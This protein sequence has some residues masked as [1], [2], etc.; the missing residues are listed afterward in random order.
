MP[1]RGI[2]LL[3]ALTVLWGANW[4][5]MKLALREVAPWTFRTVCLVTGGIGLLGIA[6]AGG[7]PLRI[8]P[9]ERGPLFLAAVFNITAWHMF[10]AY[11]V[12]LIQASRAVIIAYTM[13]LWT[14]LLGRILFGEPLTRARGVALVLGLAGLAVLIGPEARIFWKAPLG[15]LLV[16]AAAISWAAGT[17]VVKQ[18]RWTMPT[19]V[20][21]GWQV[22]LGGLPVVI[23]Q[24]LFEPFP[25]PAD[26]SLQALL[27]T[28]Y[29][30]V[31]GI[32]VCHYAWFRVVELLPSAIAAIGTLGIPVVGVWSSGL[33]LGEPVGTP[34]LAALVLVVLAL[35][36]VLF[37]RSA[38]SR[39]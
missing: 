15:A 28:A 21:T 24:L 38:L 10:S 23:G 11:G 19:I 35:A 27:G 17:V 30:A 5:A 1:L 13:P 16:L 3:G 32:I 33:I 39:G 14:V 8:A 2:L 18:F 9:Q 34:E 36:I 7:H 12:S 6:R 29:S 25:P 20:L 26:L 31:I 4:P 22:A 37:G